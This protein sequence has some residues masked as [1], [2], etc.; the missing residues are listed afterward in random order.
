MVLLDSNVF[1]LDRFFPHDALYSQN[2]IFVEKLATSDAAVSALTLL[3]VCGAASFRLSVREIESWL[4]C[5]TA[6]YPVYV[7][8]VHGLKGKESEAWWNSF[9]EEVAAHIAIR[10]TFGD[11]SLLREAENYD[12]EAIIYLEHEGLFT[13]HSDRC[14]HSHRFPTTTLTVE[15]FW[16]LG[17]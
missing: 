15:S 17:R 14:F 4:F 9:V 2:R 16:D 6:L 8:D 5:F 3:E 7:L 11:A 12:V 10:I 1:I 13:S